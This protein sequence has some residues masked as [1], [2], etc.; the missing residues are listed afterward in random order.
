MENSVILQNMSR[1][2]LKNDIKEILS[3]VLSEKTSQEKFLSRKDVTQKFGV[4]LPTVDRALEKGQLTGY[5]IGHRILMKE[6][7]VEIG[8]SRFSKTKK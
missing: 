1:D 3:E 4:C 5:R 7:E 8:L 2:D 6:S